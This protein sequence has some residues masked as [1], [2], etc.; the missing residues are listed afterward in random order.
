M[1]GI[2]SGTALIIF[3]AA[4]SLGGVA[5][6]SADEG[7]DAASQDLDPTYAKWD[8]FAK[9]HEMPAHAGRARVIGIRGRDSDGNV[10]ST[11]IQRGIFDDSLVLLGADKKV[12]FLSVST[13]PWETNSSASPDVDGDGKGDVGMLLPGRYQAVARGS[14]ANIAGL[15][16]FHVVNVDGNDGLAGVRNTEH[17]DHYTQEEFDASSARGDK[18][19]AI[20]FHKG[21]DG[22]PN[23]I[24]C[25]VLDADG[26]ATL[27]QKAGARFDY[28]LVDANDAD[29]L[30]TNE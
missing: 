11:I 30:P 18:L 5:C 26:I 21:G 1:R 15:P 19:T 13:H 14:A 7:V 10:H 28:L 9:A 22:A 12:T 6:S 25:Q 16:T 4:M 8:A 27:S 24:G 2:G 17:L 20:L 23:A 3:A 29:D